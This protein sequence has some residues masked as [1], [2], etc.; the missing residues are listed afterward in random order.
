MDFDDT[1][2]EAVFRAEARSWLEEHAPKKTEDEQGSMALFAELP[3]EQERKLVAAAKAWQHTKYEGG[4]AGMTWPK[5]YGGR[6][7][8]TMQAII[9]G[10]EE[11]RCDVPSGVWE[12][13]QGMIA[14][15]IIVHGTEE[16]KERWLPQ[17]LDGSEIWCQLYSEP[18]AGGDLGSLAT[19][20]ERDGDEWV[21]NGQKVWTSGAHYSTWGYILARTDPEQTKHRGITAFCLRMDTS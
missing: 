21:V 11:A 14:P 15:T 2:E 19:R 4:W 16:Q 6:G 10:Q 1:P 5:E 7:G 18:G 12:I 20:A 9:W 3:A 8:T 13:T 17:I